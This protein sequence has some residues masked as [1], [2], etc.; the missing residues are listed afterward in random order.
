MEPCGLCVSTSAQRPVL[1]LDFRQPR[2]FPAAS[3][4]F[5]LVTEILVCYIVS[6]L[7]KDEITLQISQSGDTRNSAHSDA[8]GRS[9]GP[10]SAA[11]GDSEASGDVDLGV[12]SEHRRRECL[13]PGT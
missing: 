2:R 11:L 12:L 13:L 3:V 9:D 8:S 7:K 5:R 6:V 10:Y 4:A 1:G